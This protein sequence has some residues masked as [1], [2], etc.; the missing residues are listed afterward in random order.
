MCVCVCVCVCERERERER[1]RVS[2][3]VGN[4]GQPLCSATLQSSVFVFLERGCNSPPP[5]TTPMGRSVALHLHL[6][7]SDDRLAFR[8]H[9]NEKEA[10]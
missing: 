3:D 10:K 6:S 8:P 4:K 9:D 1:E 2:L 5:P 7:V